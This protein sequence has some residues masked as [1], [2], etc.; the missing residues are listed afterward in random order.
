MQARKRD[1]TLV[2]RSLRIISEGSRVERKL[3]GAVDLVCS[4]V[5]AKIALAREEITGVEEEHPNTNFLVSGEEIT[6][7]CYFI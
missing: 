2:T 1:M 3:G 5:Y 6:A 4:R 7:E